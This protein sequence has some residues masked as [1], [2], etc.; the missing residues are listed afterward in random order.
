MKHT[1][2]KLTVSSFLLLISLSVIAQPI[3]E[4]EIG[5]NIYKAGLDKIPLTMIRYTTPTDRLASFKGKLIILDFWTSNCA[6]CI[7]AMPKMDSLQKRFRDKIVILPVNEIKQINQR[8]LQ[9]VDSFWTTNKFTKRTSLPTIVDTILRNY[10]PHHGVPHEVWINAQGDVVGLTNAEYVNAKEI[11]KVLR[12]EKVSW[13][14][15][16][17]IADY[18]YQ[19]P[20]LKLLPNQSNSS[21]SPLTYSAVTH[22][23]PYVLPRFGFE[24]DSIQGYKRLYVINFPIKRLYWLT[25]KETSLYGYGK[26]N[27]IQL[28]TVDPSR[29]IFSKGRQYRAE[30]EQE[31]TYCFETRVPLSTP[32]FILFDAMRK[33]LDKTF[34]LDSGIERRLV[35]VLLMVRYKQSNPTKLTSSTRSLSTKKG[36]D[37]SNNTLKMSRFSSALELANHLNGLDNPPVLD[38]TGLVGPIEVPSIRNEN[39]LEEVRQQLQTSGLDLIPGKRWMEML[40]IREIATKQ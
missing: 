15:N 31:N 14:I 11:E 35:D 18:D 16:K 13:L 20:M 4:L 27:R 2:A 30:W 8:T 12:G 3:K 28:L 17:Q 9:W 1:A 23:L 5:D 40:V 10:F 33:E 25:L 26:N 7:A 21:L 36:T 24:N 19:Q 22:N 38:E 39:N 32:D 37:D 29:Y 34:G 6:S